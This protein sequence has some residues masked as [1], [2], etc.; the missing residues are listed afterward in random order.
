[1]KATIKVLILV[2]ILDLFILPTKVL[3]GNTINVKS[4]GAVA[5]DKN[6]D[7]QAFKN[8]INQ[9]SPGDTLYIPQGR[10]LISESL[11]F[12]KSDY[13]I[14]GDGERSIIEYT[15]NQK[16]YVVP[17]GMTFLSRIT[18]VNAEK[19]TKLDANGNEYAVPYPLDQYNTECLAANADGT[20][21]KSLFDIQNGSRNVVIKNLRVTNS[22]YF[23]YWAKLTEMKNEDGTISKLATPY[24]APISYA[25]VM[26]GIVIRQVENITVDNIIADGFNQAGLLVYTGCVDPNV[27][28]ATCK[29][30]RN[31]AITNSTFRY[32]RVAGLEIGNGQNVQVANNTFYK[33]GSYYD[34]ETGYGF[35]GY[36]GET[37]QDITVYNNQAVGNYRKGIDFH[38]GRNIKVLNNYLENN[39]LFGINVTG[40]RVNDIL[41][42]GNTITGMGTPDWP[43]TNFMNPG[44]NQP[45]GGLQGWLG[46]IAAICFGDAY[47]SRVFHQAVV[48]NNRILNFQSNY[49]GA[50]VF[51]IYKGFDGSVNG[52]DYEIEITNNYAE[53]SGTARLVHM[54]GTMFYPR[55]APTLEGSSLGI[56][57]RIKGNEFVGQN[58]IYP[59]FVMKK[60]QTLDFSDNSI[61]LENYIPATKTH[62]FLVGNEMPTSI[63][64]QLSY[65]NNCITVTPQESMT[66]I[67]SHTAGGNVVFTSTGNS[68]NGK[69]LETNGAIG[70]QDLGCI[71]KNTKLTFSK[72]ADKNFT[73]SDDT[74]TFTVEATNVSSETL[75][76]I[77][78]TDVIA[79]GASFI[80]DSATGSPIFS[81]NTLKWTAATL[82]AKKSIKFKYQV[83][84]K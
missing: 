61:K 70:T 46:S 80:P 74:V 79:A 76:N 51:L 16:C 17:S 2:V 48:K 50:Y 14:S 58:L 12:Q 19:A 11:K 4:T 9:L 53:F 24:F 20:Y 27:K 31:I 39:R 23:G 28:N 29:Y 10:Y 63:D 59:P 18:P 45:L 75:K 25:G 35:A 54:D 21:S 13:T 34:Y 8:A 38:N 57:L 60:Y 83:K 33:N 26:P 73:H 37:V 40:N 52:E 77:T 47:E 44:L 78:I 68:F 7:T 71:L 32:N 81:D 62:N 84:I 41:V 66:M 56:K 43:A 42:E 64:R 36:S 82:P 72:S 15:Y 3:A 55:G 5:N 1:M 30:A 69:N 49:G 65:T 6:D 22:G 67:D